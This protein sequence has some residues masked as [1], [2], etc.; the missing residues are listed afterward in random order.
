MKLQNFMAHHCLLSYFSVVAR[1]TAFAL[2]MVQP[3]GE[4]GEAL[5][6]RLS[7]WRFRSRCTQC[8]LPISAS[9]QQTL[10]RCILLQNKTETNAPESN[11]SVTISGKNWKMQTSK[12]SL[13]E[14]QRD[15]PVLDQIVDSLHV[16]GVHRAIVASAQT[17]ANGHW[18]SRQQHLV[19]YFLQIGLVD[20]FR[21]SIVD[22]VHLEITQ[23]QTARIQEKF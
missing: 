14:L 18:R 13:T 10:G 21:I 8:H 9:S 22:K 16:V 17:A 12:H 2:R 5:E 23:L 4:A 11:I 3:S 1:S 6:Y 15:M 7:Y 19:V 20:Y